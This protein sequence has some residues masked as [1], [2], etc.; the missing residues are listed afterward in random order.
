[1]TH[2]NTHT[3]AHTGAH[4]AVVTQIK[5]TK[6]N[7]FAAYVME[8]YQAGSAGGGGD[9]TQLPT[10]AQRETARVGERENERET[11]RAESLVMHLTHE[12]LLAEI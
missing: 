9:R 2:T 11:T 6:K 5:H 1:M 3:W 7:V 4:A 8:N 10:T 12:K